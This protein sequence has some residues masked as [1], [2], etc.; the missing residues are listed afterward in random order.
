MSKVEGGAHI[1]YFTDLIFT[2]Y[3]QF[4]DITNE[5]ISV[6]IQNSKKIKN[7]TA[8]IDGSPCCFFGVENGKFFISTKSILNKNSFKAFTLK[9]IK[10]QWK[11]NKTL[12]E[13]LSNAY[14]NLKKLKKII[15]ENIIY[16]GDILFSNNEIDK[17]IIDENIEIQPN[18][19]IYHVDKNNEKYQIIKNSNFGIVLHSIY[20]NDNGKLIPVPLDLNVN[21]FEHIKLL[22]KN[23]NMFIDDVFFTSDQFNKLQFDSRKIK[24]YV[25]QLITSQPQEQLSEI[26]TKSGLQ[27]MKTLLR[28][29]LKISNN[30]I[31]SLS[32]K[33]S[34]NDVKIQNYINKF[35]RSNLLL[36]LSSTRQALIS[37]PQKQ[38]IC[39]YLM[40]FVIAN[41]IQ[42]LILHQFNMHLKKYD[43]Q[44][45]NNNG[46]IEQTFGEG[47]VL[48]Y[49]NDN[50]LKIVKFVDR[51]QF[52]KINMINHISSK[53]I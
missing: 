44:T 24:I 34:Y 53:E 40:C 35:V 49:I 22:S 7:L 9:Q 2:D 48:S 19:I 13:I 4:L 29:D 12:V 36:S 42:E 20:K 6:K 27:K 45:I 1:E 52:T 30:N 17:K 50:Q 14:R 32:E 15:P 28:K 33:Y 23:I 3:Q 37:E 31:F 47:Y 5:I 25:D 21:I 38:I 46:K 51:I 43:N 16:K 18:T 41:Q 8:K 11:N 39:K 10:Q 26:I